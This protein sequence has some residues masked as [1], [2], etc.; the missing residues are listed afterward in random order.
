MYRNWLTDEYSVRTASCGREALRKLDPTV[1]VVLL[2]RRMAGL[3]G[4][5]TATAIRRRVSDCH[6][7]MVTGMEPDTDIVE[8]EI[9]EYVTKPLRGPELR[10]VVERMLARTAYRAEMQELFALASIKA[11]L[12]TE[13]HVSIRRDDAEYAELCRQL[14]ETRERLS[15]A[16]ATAE[17]DWDEAFAACGG[18]TDTRTFGLA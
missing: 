16:H 8:M 17:M 5:R 10:T 14:T 7:V 6:V 15:S 11:T 3:S 2:D 9:D 12:E 18:R 13:R 1:D 4:A